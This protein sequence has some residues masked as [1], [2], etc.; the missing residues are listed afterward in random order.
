MKS[1]FP[2]ADAGIEA[3]R[4]WS[5]QAE[6]HREALQQETEALCSELGSSFDEVFWAGM[7]EEDM[8]RH[9]F[10]LEVVRDA[11]ITPTKAAYF[12][13]QQYGF[14]L[15]EFEKRLFANA[16]RRCKKKYRREQTGKRAETTVSDWQARKIRMATRDATGESS[17]R[18]I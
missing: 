7:S 11:S 1:R 6:A 3:Y 13:V 8:Q 12:K 2:F 16:M 15:F 5:D 17:E 14:E 4:A 10:L 9:D 18:R